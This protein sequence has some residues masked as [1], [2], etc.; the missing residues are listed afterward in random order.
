MFLCPEAQQLGIFC[1]DMLGTDSTYYLW[2]SLYLPL[3]ISKP[4]VKVINS[5]PKFYSNHPQRSSVTD[6]SLLAVVDS[7]LTLLS[8]KGNC[9]EG[10]SIEQTEAEDGE[11]SASPMKSSPL[12]S[13]MCAFSLSLSFH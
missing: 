11:A 13:L 4:K 7:I 2:G 3:N 12:K 10:L 8:T 6:E 9:N 5:L 1:V